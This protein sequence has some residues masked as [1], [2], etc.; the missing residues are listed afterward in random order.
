MRKAHTEQTCLASSTMKKRR[1]AITHLQ[2]MTARWP[3]WPI[4]P[5]NILV[6]YTSHSEYTK[7]INS[8][9]PSSLSSMCNSSKLG[10]CSRVSTDLKAFL[11]Q[12][13]I[14]NLRS[15]RL[16]GKPDTRFPDRSSSSNS[17]ILEKTKGSS[18]EI[19]LRDKSSLLMSCKVSRLKVHKNCI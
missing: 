16:I 4:P 5:S 12:F 18:V 9:T 15:P 3:L 8:L 14:L 11:L 10:N 6:S 1:G 17:C 19:F 2:Y 7:S 13:K